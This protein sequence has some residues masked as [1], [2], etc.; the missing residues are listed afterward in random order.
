MLSP[1][2]HDRI[3]AAVAAA[4]AR[5]SGEILCVLS[6]KVSDYREVPLAWAAAVALI[7]P[8]ILMALGLHSWLISDTGG[9]W[10]ATNATSL[11][12]SIG[13]A[14]TSYAI[15]QIVIFA[16]VAVA[17]SAAAPLRLALTPKSLK[18]QRVRQAALH[19]LAATGLLGAGGAV[20]IFAAEAERMVTVVADEALHLK[21]GDA[22]W[23]AA[24]AAVLSGIR[25]HDPASG[26]I[27]AI[28]VCG[29][30]LAAHFPAD[31]TRHNAVSDRLIEI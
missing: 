14:L 18:T 29:G 28:E 26:F 21:A 1:A 4:E 7:L 3:A 5:T 12:A 6:H 27:A 24:V 17:L 15:V 30:Y 20:V 11:D 9:D 8:P 31:G 2:D 16:A 19:H 22:A 10:V 25:S 13:L 23:D